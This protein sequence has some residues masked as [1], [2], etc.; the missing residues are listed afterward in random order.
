MTKFSIIVNSHNQNNYLERCILSILN[1]DTKEDFEIIVSDTSDKKYYELQENYKE[2]KNIKFLFLESSYQYPTQDQLYKIESAIKYCKGEYVC[3]IDGDDFFFNKKLYFISKE[4]ESFKYS[5]IQDWPMIYDESL[6]KSKKLINLSKYY[7]NLNIY[8]K[9]VNSWPLV[10][11]TSCLTIKREVI[12]NFFKQTKPFDYKY[13]AIDILIAIYCQ[14][15]Y[16]FKN[17]NLYLTYKSLGVKNL[18]K[19]FSKI[20]SKN[21]WHRRQEQHKYYINLFNKKKIFK[22]IDYYLTNIMCYFLKIIN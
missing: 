3:L 14:I 10:H 21:Y 18:D 12:V 19:T 9:L 6:K 20:I 13:L 15:F 1:Q 22:G 8:K 11:S 7:K 17:L 4:L 2:Y 16:D 5:C